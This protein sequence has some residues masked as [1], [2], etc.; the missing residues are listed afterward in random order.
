VYDSTES[1]RLEV[2]VQ[3][4][5]LSGQKWLISSGG[6]G[7][8]RWREDGKEIFYL[9]EDGRVM[10]AELKSDS[11]FENIV[12]K[13]LFQSE[14]KLLSG[15]PFTATPDGSRFLVNTPAEANN[16]APMV[17]LVNWPATLKQKQ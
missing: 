3:T 14:I 5:P 7:M 6:G 2:Y 9:T 12:T 10:S 11:S 15:Y 1:G 13:Q 17:V 4:F 8:P 16:P